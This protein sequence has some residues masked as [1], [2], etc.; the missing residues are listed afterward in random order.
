MPHIEKHAPG[1]FCWIELGTT[2]Q[3]AAKEFYCALLG[4]QA[5]EIAVGPG[6]DHIRFVL[7]G[8]SVAG[9][10]AIPPDQAMPPNWSLYVA[11]EDAGETAA[12]A[13]ALGGTVLCPAADVATFG[14]MAGILDPT[15]AFFSI[16]QAKDRIGMGITGENGAFC[17]ADLNTTDRRR[18]KAFYAALFGWQ[19]APGKDKTDDSYL[20]IK[21]GDAYIGGIP[22]D[23]HRDRNAPPHWLIYFLVADCDASTAKAVDLGGRV[24]APPASVEP[25]LRFS[26]LADPQRAVF[27]LFAGRV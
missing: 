8:R 25:N 12:R 4:W 9:C 1:S 16:W 15:G 26:V 23:E 7:D 27:A 24:Y 2:D 13:E 6:V 17:W 22:P 18:A 11:V 5:Q 10:G 3:K 21:T 20:H 14:R 19:L